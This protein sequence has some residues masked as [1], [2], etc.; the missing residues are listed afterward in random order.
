MKSSDVEYLFELMDA[1]NSPCVFAMRA[2]FFS[3]VCAVSAVPDFTLALR[4][5]LIYDQSAYLIGKSFSWSH[6]PACIA[7][8][9]CSEVAMRYLSV[10]FSLSPETLYSSSS[11]CS[12]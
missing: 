11:N 3:V 4:D 7:E 5:L 8:I 12:S 2:C 1:E 6:S 10:S 9:G